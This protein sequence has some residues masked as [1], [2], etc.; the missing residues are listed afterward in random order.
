MRLKLAFC[1]LIALGIP[2]AIF[3]QSAQGENASGLKNAVILI[4]RHAEKTDDGRGLSSLGVARAK[5]YAAYFKNFTID[6][7]AFEAGRHLRQQGRSE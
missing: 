4:I 2:A 5:A 3:A 7:R 1:A 6:G